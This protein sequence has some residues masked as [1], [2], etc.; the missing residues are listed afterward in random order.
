M[1]IRPVT[2]DVLH[3]EGQTDGHTLYDEANSHVSQFCRR[4]SQPCARAR[5][6]THTH[7]HLCTPQISDNKHPCSI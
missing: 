2:A 4:T 3:A 7:T 6:R 1:K 5:A